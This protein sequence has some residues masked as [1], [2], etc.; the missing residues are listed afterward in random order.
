MKFL[1]NFAIYKK[2]PDDLGLTS[3]TTN[4]IPVTIETTGLAWDSLK[5]SRFK[6]ASGSEDKQWVNP[7]SGKN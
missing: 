2:M 6:Q 1:D 3:S 7:E 5:G 4:D